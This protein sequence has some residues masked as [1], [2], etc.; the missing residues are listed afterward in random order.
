MAISLAIGGVYPAQGDDVKGRSLLAL[1]FIGACLSACSHGPELDNGH[2]IAAEHCAPCH[3]MTSTAKVILAP[4]LWGIYQR[5][6]GQFESFKYSPSFQDQARKDRFVWNDINLDRYLSDP[7]EVIPNN[8]MSAWNPGS[9]PAHTAPGLPPSL[10]SARASL[11]SMGHY[12][13][14]EGFKNDSD[15]RDLIAFLKTLRSETKE[16]H[17]GAA[18]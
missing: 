16:E 4:P 6:M 18:R 8:L 13:P 1:V 15:R 12:E 17:I 5:P 10:D 2:R 3:D 9:T 14:F 11:A 7:R